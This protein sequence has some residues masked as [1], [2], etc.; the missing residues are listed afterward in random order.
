MRLA[1]SFVMLWIA[2]NTALGCDETF[3]AEDIAPRMWR[4]TG[5][6]TN[7]QPLDFYL[8]GVSHQ[9][10]SVEYDLAPHLPQAPQARGGTR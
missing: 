8:L 10:L 5:V 1:Y 4:V 9:G 2:L 6:G 7:G 3:A